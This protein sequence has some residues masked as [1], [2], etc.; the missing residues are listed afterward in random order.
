MTDIN[1]IGNKVEMNHI[2]QAQQMLIGHT[3][4]S[5]DIYYTHI[6]HSIIQLSQKLHTNNL[7]PDNQCSLCMSWHPP[8]ENIDKFKYPQKRSGNANIYTVQYHHRIHNILNL[9][10][11]LTN[12]SRAEATKMCHD[13]D[14]SSSLFTFFTQEELKLVIDDLTL[15]GSRGAPLLVF[16]G[17]QQ[18]EK[19]S[20]IDHESLFGYIFLWY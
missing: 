19:A 17:F 10:Q 14:N 12:I 2:S 9:Q 8:L 18:D 1:G 20:L 11:E 5:T 15:H 16:T 7:N 3:P 4:M 13:N 6:A